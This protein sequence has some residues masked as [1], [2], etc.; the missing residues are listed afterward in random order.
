[1]GSTN[2]LFFSIESSYPLKD[3][4]DVK[5]VYRDHKQG[6]TLT[7]T[8]VKD[9]NVPKGVKLMKPKGFTFKLLQTIP[10]SKRHRQKQREW[11]R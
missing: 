3:K 10:R 1:M 7:N 6:N 5:K 9:E 8:N 2:L 11:R 4:L